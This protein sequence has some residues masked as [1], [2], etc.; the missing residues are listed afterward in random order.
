LNVAGC[1]FVEVG[2]AFPGGGRDEARSGGTY[3]HRGSNCVQALRDVILFAMGKI[4][5]G[6]GRKIQ[7]LVGDIRVLT[8]NVGLHGGSHGG[9]ACGAVM[10]LYGQDFPKLAWYVSM[11]SP[12]GEGAVGAE[13]G[14]RRGRLCPAYDSETGTLDLTKLAFDPSSEIRPF[15]T[16]RFGAPSLPAL[17]G[18]LFFD[19]DGDGKCESEDDYPLQPPVFDVGQGRKAWY[20]VRLIRE[21]ERRNLF[22]A[23]RPVHIPSLDE[24][25]ESWRYRDATG[26][27]V[28]AVRKIP[29]L[30]AIVVAGETDHVQIAPDHP[31]IR[32]QVNAFQEAGAKLIRLNPDRAYVEWLLDR[33]APGLPDADAGLRYTPK[34]ISAALCPDRA[35]PK[36]LLSP[37]AMCELADRVQARNF[38]PNLD[39]VLFPDAPKASGPPPGLK[40]RPTNRKGPP[41]RRVR[42]TGDVGPQ[43]EGLPVAWFSR[44][45]S[46]GSGEPGYTEPPTQSGSLALASGVGSQLADLPQN[47]NWKPAPRADSHPALARRPQSQAVV[48]A[49]NQPLIRPDVGTVSDTRVLSQS[50][51]E[52][53]LVILTPSKPRYGEGAPVVINVKPA[54]QPQPAGRADR[55]GLTAL[56]FVVINFGYPTGERFDQGGPNCKRALADVLLFA[57]GKTTDIQGRHMDELSPVEVQ[58]G[59]VGAIGWSHGGNA[60]VTTL[61]LHPD[62]LQDLAFYVSYESPCGTSEE[63][64]G[65]IVNVDY[66]GVR[67]DPDPRRDA[68]GNGLPWD[69]GRNPYYTP[70]K[71]L[72]FSKL[73]W[74]PDVTWRWRLAPA[75]GV[76]FLDGNGNGKF[77]VVQSGLSGPPRGNVTQTPD[78]NHD[79]RLGKNEDFP[80]SFLH[81]D[82]NG[83][84]RRFYSL[85]VTKAAAKTV[86]RNGFP[87]DVAAV[88]QAT[89]YWSERDMA[90]RFEQL[91][92]RFDDL[93][94]CIYAGRQDHVQAQSDCPHI[95][96][97]YTGLRRAGIRWVRI[98]PDPVYA[99]YVLGHCEHELP[100]NQPNQPV[101]AETMWQKTEPARKELGNAFVAAGVC[102]L[103]DRAKAGCEE[104][105]GDSVLFPDAPKVRVNVADYFW[106]TEQPE[107]ED[108][109]DSKTLYLCAIIHN[110]ED[111]RPRGPTGRADFNGDRDVLAFTT[112]QYR[113]IGRLFQKYDAKINL[114]CDWTFADGARKFDPEFFGDWEA[115]GHDTDSHA[116]ESH[117]SYSEVKQRLRAAGAHPTRVIGGTLEDDIQQRLERFETVWPEF[118]VLWG[119][120]T[121]HHRLPEEKT[122]YVWRPAKSESWFNHDPK[123]KIIYVGGNARPMQVETIREAHANASPDKVNVYSIFL[124]SFEAPERS[125]CRLG[126]AS[127]EEFLRQV[128]ELQETCD[129]QWKSLTEVAEIFKRREA[130]GSL[131]FSDI[132]INAIPRDEP[133]LANPGRGS[134]KP[135]HRSEP[136]READYN[137]DPELIDVVAASAKLER[138]LVETNS[139]VG[140]EADTRE[141][142]YALDS[143]PNGAPLA[144]FEFVSPGVGGSGQAAKIT[145]EAG[146]AGMLTR[147]IPADKGRKT[148]FSVKIRAKGIES[149]E[150]VAV[151]LSRQLQSKQPLRPGAGKPR[152]QRPLRPFPPRNAGPQAKPGARPPRRVAIDRSKALNGTFDWTTLSLETTFTTNFDAAQFQ[153]VVRGPGTVWIDDMSVK[154]QMPKI[155]DIPEEPLAPLYVM[156]MMHSETPRAYITDRGYFRADAMK[157]EQMAKM[158]HRY[159]ARLVIQPEREL[160]LGAKQYDPDFLRRL[161]DNYGAS[162]SVHTHGPIPTSTDQEVL[163]YIRLRKEEMEAMGAGSVTD[164][165]GNFERKD[166]NIFAEIG[167]RTVT[168]YK[169]PP[170]QLGLMAM[171]H[172]YLHPWRPSGSPFGSEQQFARHNPNCNVV[173]LP[174]V[175]AEHTRNHDLFA[176]LIE[177]HLRVA[178]SRVRADRINVTYFVEHVGRFVPEG[179]RKSSWEYVNSQEFRDDLEQHEKLYRDFL[180]PLVKS[181]HVR[182]AVPSEVCDLFER[183]EQKMGIAPG[184]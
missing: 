169:H 55:C 64:L 115:M 93:L 30:A 98:N 149:V 50:R 140:L 79:G 94:V 91:E 122:G 109:A 174:G 120:A 134:K 57:M 121:K 106:A 164:T 3:D 35:A 86:F 159:G 15:G 183:W 46:P 45:G 88:E 85:S 172:Y 96:A 24:A 61:Q 22:G 177:R 178:L 26:L 9:N 31:H 184:H 81:G 74:D 138:E 42:H 165:N 43:R 92:S 5:D 65:D 179:R 112:D 175:G 105:L 145:A 142:D 33:E 38:E 156:T 52:I 157:Y 47:A 60:V 19:M 144:T 71:T 125:E 160:W 155:V 34:T 163:D 89:A 152:T 153:V 13:L 182:Y 14:S 166:W 48:R 44:T 130:E 36:Q 173:F 67:F 25:I 141:E 168:S 16:G 54:V 76:L 8:S 75:K 102:E 154:T 77:D 162:F 63:S 124:G 27:V 6:Q 18:G 28:D 70:D 12:Y 111:H 83:V 158:L 10:G 1:G 132:D 114:Q 123:G 72:D 137:N 147:T 62:E 113:K 17:V 66:G 176:N 21:A 181:G 171:Q 99:R 2:F 37:A 73:C 170:T 4:A 101:A 161:H 59:V 100:A 180:A 95:R 97:Q 7:D 40:R 58:T 51:S 87:E 78:T 104:P 150:L 128:Q 39:R 148:I 107:A 90:A 49:K 103:A 82:A 136:G 127:F 68:D 117:V 69:D 139:N 84:G 167:L 119:V 23:P 135:I 20:S 110:E 118:E 133:G 126:L 151:P 108:K 129:V 56:G 146:Q 131:N 143:L 29:D 11:E 80:L 32:A 41:P 53:E 116:H